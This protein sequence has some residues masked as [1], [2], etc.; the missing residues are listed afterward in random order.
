[1]NLGKRQS[2]HLFQTKYTLGKI[3]LYAIYFLLVT[4]C[5]KYDLGMVSSWLQKLNFI[6]NTPFVF[7]VSNTVEASMNT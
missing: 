7:A 1:M 4:G 3:S 6:C 5:G 2:L